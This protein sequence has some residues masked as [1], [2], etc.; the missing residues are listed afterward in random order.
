MHIGGRAVSIAVIAA[1]IAMLAY[2]LLT[3]TGALEPRR[4]EAGPEYIEAVRGLYLLELAEKECT[5]T[6]SR[7]ITLP[8]WDRIPLE[9]LDCE[10]EV[11]VCYSVRVTAGM[12]LSGASDDIIRIEGR[13]AD[14]T[15]P[16]PE[17]VNTVV[18][19]SG[20]SWIRTGG[21]PRNWDEELLS[22]R[23]EMSALAERE[24]EED[25]MNS[26]I[27]QEAESVATAHVSRALA[28]LGI[29]ETHVSFE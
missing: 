13:R 15:L 4:I 20:S 18:R 22:A 19:E 17:L 5:F 2:V 25:A 12:D 9:E 21:M 16:A 6:L 3:R 24:A 7:T 26:G 29:E 8:W 27:I 11:G 10:M 23:A 28:S 14:I 1:S